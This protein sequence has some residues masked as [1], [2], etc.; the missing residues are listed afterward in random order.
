MTAHQ[1]WYH[2]GLRF[3]CT[4]CGNCCTSHGEYSYVY[5]AAPDQE[6]LAAHLGLGVTEFLARYCAEED[7]Y[8]LLRMDQPEC[9]FLTPERTCSVYPARPKQCRTW[10]F[11]E[12]NLVR[13][14]WEGP[15]AEIC[16]GLGQG[17]L[18]PAAEVER[19][20]RETE[21]WYAGD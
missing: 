16:P 20:A 4:R 10:P 11:W 8:V 21:E 15:V 5:V 6:A 12:E 13:A 14:R 1:A 2:E 17:E 9:P 7:G 19:L 3:S 18:H